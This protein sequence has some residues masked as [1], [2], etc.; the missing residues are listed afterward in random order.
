MEVCTL[1][2]FGVV[3]LESKVISTRFILKPSLTQTCDSSPDL[4]DYEENVYSEE[5][6]FLWEE[7]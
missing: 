4:A 3:R 2:K 1:F 6:H 5:D 7:M